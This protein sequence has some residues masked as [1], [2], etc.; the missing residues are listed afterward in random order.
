MAST[1]AAAYLSLS[2]NTLRNKARGGQFPDPVPVLDGRRRW[3]RVDLDAWIERQG[4]RS[5]TRTKVAVSV[6]EQG[7]AWDAALSGE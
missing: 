2:V 5:P 7:A 1:E 6:E 4:R 3:R